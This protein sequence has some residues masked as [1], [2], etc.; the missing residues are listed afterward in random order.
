MTRVNKV[1]SSKPLV[2][3]MTL[4]EVLIASALMAIFVTM[5]SQLLLGGYRSNKPSKEQGELISSSGQALAALGN[6]LRDSDVLMRPTRFDW[7][8]D[9]TYIPEKEARPPIVLRRYNAI[10]KQEIA[11]AYQWD[12]KTNQLERFQC[13]SPFS[14]DLFALDP[15]PVP[16]SFTVVAPFVQNFKLS[17]LGSAYDFLSREQFDLIQIDLVVSRNHL[18]IPLRYQ[19]RV[20]EL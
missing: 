14:L 3:G 6:E 8:E 13:S 4:L 16:G 17:R 12:P 20:H 18:T 5:V 2:R 11:V 7:D 1:V 10:T 19:V 9:E 15:E